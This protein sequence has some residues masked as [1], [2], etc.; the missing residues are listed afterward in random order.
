MGGQEMVLV[1]AP[2]KMSET[3]LL[4]LKQKGI[5]FAVL[6]NNEVEKK[7]LEKLGVQHIISVDTRNHGSW[8]PP[9]FK[10]GSVYL[11]ENSLPLCCRYIQIC[12]SWTDKPIYVV[13]G[14]GH[15]R[16]IYKAL[17]VDHVVLTHRGEVTRLLEIR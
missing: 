8:M 12:R 17:G 15:S 7:R 16:M 9:G 13:T 14:S 6:T 3:F 5:L 1:F 4:C 11:F 2:T 10:I